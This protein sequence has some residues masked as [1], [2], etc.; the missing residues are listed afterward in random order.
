MD[1]G[2]EKIDMRK[3]MNKIYRIHKQWVAA[4]AVAIIASVGGIAAAS[5]SQ[6]REIKRV[7]A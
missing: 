4:V 1:Q 6:D 7:D 2:N 3:L 5:H